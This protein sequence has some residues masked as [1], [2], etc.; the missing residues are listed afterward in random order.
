MDVSNSYVKIS[1]LAT[2]NKLRFFSSKHIM[3]M[4]EYYIKGGVAL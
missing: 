2:A 4:L 3:E 1:N